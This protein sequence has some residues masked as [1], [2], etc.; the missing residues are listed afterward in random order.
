MKC[1]NYVY[2][3]EAWK[4]YPLDKRQRKPKGQSRLDNSETLVTLGTQDTGP[5]QT[6]HKSTTQKYK[7]MS[8]TVSS[9]NEKERKKIP[10]TAVLLIRVLI[11]SLFLCL[12]KQLRILYC[13]N[14]IDTVINKW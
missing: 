3:R 8:T 4:G 2:T 5:R 9:K 6:N 10:N 11:G 14:Y 12:S 1:N 7:N 13:N